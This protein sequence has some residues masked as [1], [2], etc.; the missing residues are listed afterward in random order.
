MILIILGSP[1]AGKGTQARNLS[2]YYNITH[3][4]TGDILREHMR[5]RTTIG[6]SINDLMD[7]GRL[8][9]DELIIG[10]VES[11][12]REDDCLGGFILD[13]FPRTLVQA[14]A[15]GT[16]SSDMGF[17]INRVVSV[18]VNDA[19]I[20]SRMT[21]RMICPDCG[22]M[23]NLAYYPPKIRGICD[24]CG[25]KL[26]QRDDDKAKTVKSR[27]KL[28]HEL[29]GPIIEYY[30]NKGLLLRVNGVGDINDVTRT[31]IDNL[32]EK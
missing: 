20:I 15:F 23:F 22:G 16:I 18:E 21:G 6:V 17:A 1:G 12:I 11:R 24:S 32:G 31:I 8:V 3:I 9:P 7:T 10:L 14:E 27:L 2:K 25:A 4:S 19:V 28:Y 26:I 5:N 30:E 29:T 13:G